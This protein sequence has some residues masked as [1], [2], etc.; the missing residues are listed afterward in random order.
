MTIH[1]QRELTH[2]RKQ[3]LTVGAT[4]ESAISNAI[5]ALLNRDVR[6][7]EQVIAGDRDVDRMEI[8]VEEEC[9]KILALHQPVATDLRFIVAVLKMNNDLERMGDHAANMAKKARFLARHD[10]QPWPPEIETMA[11]RTKEMVGDS[12]EA[13][14]NQ[15]TEQARRVWLADQEV[16]RF[17]RQIAD[18]LR[19]RL[20]TG[21]VAGRDA[22][23]KMLDI[24]RHLERI[25]DLATNIAEDVVY[26][27]EGAITRHRHE[28]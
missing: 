2:L 17:K 4:V 27:A 11:Q 19:Q 18:E 26:M 21:E 8:E 20:L 6:M 16:D 13:L 28:E 3:I 10:P 1:F 7:A 25:A 24:P 14:I 5:T 15:N 9:L 22:L 12:L 23:L